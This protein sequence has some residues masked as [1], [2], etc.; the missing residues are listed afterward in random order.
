MLSLKT[1]IP[2]ITANRLLNQTSMANEKANQQLSSGQRI[3]RAAD[4]A[5]GLAM[6]EKMRAEIR[7]LGA[8]KANSENGV[9][10]VQTA[11][12][13]LNEISNILARLR[14]LSIQAASDTIGNTERQF[15]Q[16]EYAQMKDEIDRIAS[17]SEFN[18]TPLL[19]GNGD[20]LPEEKKLN[21]NM[22]PLEIQVGANYFDETDAL[23]VSKPQN[24]IR[25]DL[26]HFNA[27]THGENSLDLGNSEDPD[28]SRIDSK[29]TAQSSIYKIDVAINQVSEFR[30]Y[31]GAIQN[32]LE[33]TSR[34]LGIHIENVTASESRIRDA[35]IAAVSADSTKTNILRQ[36][37][38]SVMAQAN[39]SPQIALK[40]L[41]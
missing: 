34:N 16:K 5:A 10:L 4:D 14:E 39:F 37:G 33:S 31:L 12:G 1:N 25:V 28:G 17:I 3:N 40:L 21:S 7:S 26:Q 15:L 41:G 9:S 30:A 2:A 20:Q 11:E 27:M 13:G 35:D 19:A 18:G 32:R 29:D 24:I 22:Y 6:S 38:T 36:A 8:A 23:S